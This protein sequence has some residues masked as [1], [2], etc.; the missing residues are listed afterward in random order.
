MKGLRAVLFDVDGVLLDSLTPHLKISEDKSLEY[1][2]GLRIPDSAE[3][4][5][6]VRAGVRISPMKLFFRAVGFPEPFAEKAD[7]D[8]Q[9]TFM[10]SYAPRPFP[11]MRETLKALQSDGLKLG[12]V[13]S[14]V[15]ANV[16]RAIGPSMGYFCADCIFAKDDLPDAPKSE[17]I[18]RALVALDV[19]PREVL[20][21]GDQPADWEAAKAAG[22]DFLGVTYGWGIS[23]QDKDFP[24]VNSISAVYPY[25]RARNQQE[26]GALPRR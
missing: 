10:E 14:N 24:T 19:G 25:V 11:G 16:L 7:A 26:S 9:Q 8:Y 3:F 23:D 1:G 17:A 15:R 18:R 22:V 13:T 21:V 5:Q 4:K 2:L 20:Y 6:M 12:I